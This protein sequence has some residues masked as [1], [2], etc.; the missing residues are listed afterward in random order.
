VYYQCRWAGRELEVELPEV[1]DLPG[2]AFASA[3]SFWRGAQAL[4]EG[5]LRTAVDLMCEA[6]VAEFE[7]NGM[8]DDL[9]VFWPMAVRV[10]WDAED[11]EAVD[12]LGEITAAMEELPVS[13]SLQG[14][15][16]A[17]S[18]LRGLRSGAMTPEEVERHLRTGI[19]ILDRAGVGTWRAWAQE[20]LGRFLL[21]RDRREEAQLQLKA[22]RETFDRMGATAWTARVDDLM[23]VPA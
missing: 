5:D 4:V 20:D 8:S 16:A 23:A 21:E 18:A 7:L 19:E 2:Q 11:E 9:H 22:A 13:H 12:R 3:G 1:T 14:H 10:A 15:L 6:V 17:F